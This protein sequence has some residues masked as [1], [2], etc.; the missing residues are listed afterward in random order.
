MLTV[1]VDHR[2]GPDDVRRVADALREFEGRAPDPPAR[3]A[4]A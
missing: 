3:G 2:C 4:A 1:P